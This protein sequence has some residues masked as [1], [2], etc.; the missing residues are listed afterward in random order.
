MRA[1]WHS[2]IVLNWGEKHEK[3]GDIEKV[4]EGVCKKLAR[5]R[6]DF[7]SHFSSSFFGKKIDM[8]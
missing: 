1:N 8:F 6:K 2:G 4:K 3:V 5:A 7:Q